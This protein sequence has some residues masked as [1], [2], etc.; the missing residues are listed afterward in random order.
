V[1]LIA[2]KNSRI[3]TNTFMSQG[4]A[5]VRQGSRKSMHVEEEEEE[6]EEAPTS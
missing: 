2:R 3:L 5:P 1:L 4:S 6:E